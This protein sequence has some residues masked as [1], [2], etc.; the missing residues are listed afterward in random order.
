MLL[1]DS[2]REKYFQLSVDP[3][4]ILTPARPFFC[5]V[6]HSEIQHFKQAVIG[7]KNRFRLRYLTQLTVKAFDRVCGVD[8]FSKLLR[9]LEVRTEV[10][11][12]I[13]P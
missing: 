7:R 8:Q 9:E 5:N 11:P 12:V 1:I 3:A 2:I 4:P 6:D 10:D 13:T